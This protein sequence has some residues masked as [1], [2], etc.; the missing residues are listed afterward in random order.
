LP[1]FDCDLLQDPYASNWLER[2]RHI[3]RLKT[4]LLKEKAGSAG[5]SVYN[6]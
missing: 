4:K 3:K 1:S 6:L 5:L 2:L